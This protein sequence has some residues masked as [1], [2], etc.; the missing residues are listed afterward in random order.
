MFNTVYYSN[1]CMVTTNTSGSI[2]KALLDILQVGPKIFKHQYKA[3]TNWKHT[4]RKSVAV[5]YANIYFLVLIQSYHN[6]TFDVQ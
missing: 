5:I 3:I 6:N 4:L 1:N 2:A